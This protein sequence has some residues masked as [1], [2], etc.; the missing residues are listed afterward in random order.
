MRLQLFIQRHALPPV[1]IIHTT[2]TGPSS[3]T[4][5]RSA[6]I[7]D[8]LTDVND[9]VPLESSDGEW[10]LED[11]VVEIAATGDQEL[12]YECLHFQA[13][14]SVLREDDE[15]VI[16]ALNNDDLRVRRLGGRHQ[17]T[18]DGRHLIDGVAFGKRWLRQ[19]SRPGIIIQARK[20]RRLLPEE[21][22]VLDT[23]EGVNRILPSSPNTGHEDHAAA[24]VPFVGDEDDDD[25]EDD[26]DYVDEDEDDAQQP[27][28]QIVLSEEFDDADGDSDEESKLDGYPE[29]GDLSSEVRQLLDDA[30][31][32]EQ[33]SN[34][35]IAGQVLEKKLKRKRTVEDDGEDEEEV[36]FEGFATA[37][38]NPSLPITNLE[39]GLANGVSSSESGDDDASDSMLDEISA[40]QEA[41]RATNIVDDNEGDMDSMLDETTALN[42]VADDE[43]DSDGSDV[44]SSSD[45]SSSE[46]D[47][48]SLSDGF[49]IQQAKQRA[50]DLIKS[51]DNGPS[52]DETSSS[53]SDTDDD[54]EVSDTTSSSGSD[55]DSDDTSE[56]GFDTSSESTSASDAESTEQNI[57]DI[58]KNRPSSGVQSAKIEL[59]AQL[60]D[61]PNKASVGIPF[62]GLKRTH[63]NNDR[64]NRRKK[65]N[66]L[67]RQGLLPQEADFQALAKYEEYLV[68]NGEGGS[69]QDAHEAIAEQSADSTNPEGVAMLDRDAKAAEDRALSEV[70]KENV[71]PQMDDGAFP[72]EP[73]A[74]AASTVPEIPGTSQIDSQSVAEPAPKR[75]RLDL[76]SSRRMIFGSL[77]VRTPQTTEQEH[78]LR[79]K[80]SQNIRQLKQAKEEHASSVSQTPQ[81]TTP[82]D[83]DAD[84]WKDRLII[85]AVECEEPG[86]VLPPPPFPFQQG[87]A[88]PNRNK[89]KMR[90]QSQYYQN[91]NDDYQEAEQPGAPDFPR[92]SYDEVSLQE[93]DGTAS[94]KVNHVADELPSEKEIEKLPP[95]EQ[96]E[97]LPGAT[98]AY[99]EL[100]VD[101]ST[102]YE[103][104]ISPY[105]VGQVSSVDKDGTVY[106]QIGKSLLDLLV[107]ANV[108]QE[109]GERI[110]GKFEIA[111][112]DADEED[113]GTRDIS[114][115]SMIKPK[116]V[117]PSSVQVPNS[118]HAPVLRGGEA[119]VSS[120][121]DEIAMVPESAEQKPESQGSA[122]SEV[123]ISKIDTPR[124]QEINGIIKEAGFESALDEELLQPIVNPVGQDVDDN[125][126]QEDVLDESRETYAHRFRRRSPRGI[127]TSSDP[128]PSSAVENDRSFDDEPADADPTGVSSVPSTSSP[129]MPTLTT[130][131]YPHI[132]QMDITSSEPARTTNSNSHQNAQKLSP[133]P[134]LD[135][136]F[137]VSAP[138]KPAEAET[139]QEAADLDDDHDG[140]KVNRHDASAAP[141]SPENPTPAPPGPS[142]P[143]EE[144]EIEQTQPPQ[145]TS[146]IIP[147]SPLASPDNEESSQQPSSFLGGPG[148]DGN[149]SSYHDSFDDNSSL[150]SLSDMLSSQKTSE[151]TSRRTSARSAKKASSPPPPPAKK[152]TRSSNVSRRRKKSPTPRSSPDLPSSSQ[153]EFKASQSQKSQPRLS[154]I[155]VGSQVVDLT[156]SSDPMSP[157]KSPPKDKYEEEDDDSEHMTSKKRNK[158]K[159]EVN[160]TT[161]K[162]GGRGTTR[163]A[164]QDRGI[165]KRTLLTKKRSSDNK[166]Y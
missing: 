128:Q 73:I 68:R 108:D 125:A 120:M 135:L 70:N 61:A 14:E 99:Q 79:E 151:P 15:V 25:E 164:S 131:D 3:H 83:D 111:N 71:R 142:S 122:K 132:S 8:L 96:A 7:A 145:V 147:S 80:L 100:H 154:Q 50:L 163:Q 140:V 101:A 162:A 155:P 65:L 95:L 67:K 31:E 53:G 129:Y 39:S 45:I 57:Q 76:A 22:S 153:T 34:L 84:S 56:S 58:E 158:N 98:I 33:T 114:F 107:K 2:G 18:S 62:E 78:K 116:L 11:Y 24:L 88:R 127:V 149:D 23:E 75:A 5:S 36:T 137:T 4:K 28:N 124:K 133:A 141:S 9:L 13:I 35:D 40:Q 159:I 138:E 93:T 19:T 69:L 63:S 66:L 60:R 166:Y 91:R 160:V 32:I 134:V 144:P 42:T 102:N 26:E 29:A 59:P 121:N 152:S 103:P 106:V 112:E 148:Y 136:S 126:A 81:A 51:S 105:R 117:K 87:W 10:G 157:I 119:P 85:S 94:L 139:P 74:D 123:V 104:A 6:T 165:G 52:E 55:S 44:T 30:A 146:D 92:L 43:D 143:I 110:Y 16:R 21:D 46:S 86:G 48:E 27:Q 156:F 90:D 41:K 12:T 72:E 49:T 38:E 77:G 37:I 89:R 47:A 130:V 1:T 109:T 161:R 118:S 17:I 115:S 82:A 113:D 20:K 150:P 97:I 64:A 54:D